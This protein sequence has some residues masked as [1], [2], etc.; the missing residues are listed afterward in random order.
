MKS[1]FCLFFLACV[2]I[3]LLIPPVLAE[4]DESHQLWQTAYNYRE[5]NKCSEAL[6]YSNRA[7]AADP[8]WAPPFNVKGA[9]LSCLGKYDESI[10]AYDKAISLSPDWEK[11]WSNKGYVYLRQSRC[12]EALDAFNKALALMP[13]FEAAKQGRIQATNC[14]NNISAASQTAPARNSETA[15]PKTSATTPAMTSPATTQTTSQTTVPTTITTRI[16]VT[17]GALPPRTLSQNARQ[18]PPAGDDGTTK[19]PIGMAIIIS[20]IGIGLFLS[21]QKKTK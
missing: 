8:S 5:E 7:I 14:Q 4:T 15:S 21:A 1:T 17:T 9:S 6:D 19:A 11:P 12:N 3:A 13:D 20:G 10:A 16:P 18:A 2:F